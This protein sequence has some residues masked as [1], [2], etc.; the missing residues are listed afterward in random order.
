MIIMMMTEISMKA[1]VGHAIKPY[2]ASLARLSAQVF[3]EYPYLCD[4]LPEVEI[5]GLKKYPET[6]ESIGV[7]IFEGTEIVG[8]ATGMPLQLEPEHVQKPFLHQ[9]LNPKK[10]FHFAEALL[11]KPYRGRGIGHHFYEIREEHAKKLGGY[12]YVCFYAKDR[13]EDDP[14]KPLDFYPL[15]DFWR[16]RGFVHHSD[17]PLCQRWKSLSEESESDKQC[18][19]WIKK[20]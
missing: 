2:L 5:E 12:E 1:F 18:S 14:L 19:F 15:D 11:L 4:T 17:L 6:E 16:K 3:R 13:V 7:L 8:A 20:L 9:G 10:Y